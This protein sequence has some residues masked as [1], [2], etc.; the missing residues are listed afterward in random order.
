LSGSNGRYL[1]PGPDQLA[2]ADLDGLGLPI[3]RA[4]AIRSLAAAF[5][6]GLRIDRGVDRVELRR[7]LLDLPGIGPWTADIIAMRAAGDPDVLPV[8]D[9]VIRQGAAAV[10]LPDDPAALVELSSP[11]SPWRSYVAHHLWATATSTRRN[12]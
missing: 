8:G 5:V 10:G 11:W 4:G 12:P 6:S 7:Q 1:F 2:E 3:T 9:L